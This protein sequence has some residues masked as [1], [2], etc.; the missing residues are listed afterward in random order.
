MFPEITLI[1][2]Q[3]TALIAIVDPLIALPLYLAFKQNKKIDESKI[4]KNVSLTVFVVLV[5]SI[6]LGQSILDFF[7]I[8]LVSFKICGGLLLLIMG[9][10]MMQGRDQKKLDETLDNE[11]D[12]IA[13]VPLGIPL[14]AGPGAISNIIIASSVNPGWINQVLLIIPV[15]IVS[16]LIWSLFTYADVVSKKVGVIGAKVITRI[17]GLILGAMAIEII[18]KAI[19]E[20]IALS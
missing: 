11:I 10:D 17:M 13:Y 3:T 12:L 14:L 2:K 1:I 15:G 7:G 18:T 4:A 19:L 20:I 16:L 6:F 9:I 5:L 8:S